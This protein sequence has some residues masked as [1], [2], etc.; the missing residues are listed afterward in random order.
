MSPLATGY[1]NSTYVDCRSHAYGPFARALAELH[2]VVDAIDCNIPEHDSCEGQ[3]Q[4]PGHSSQTSS[5]RNNRSAANTRPARKSLR[6]SDPAHGPRDK[7]DGKAQ[8]PKPGDYERKKATDL[9]PRLLDCPVYKHWFMWL[10]SISPP[11]CNGCSQKHMTQIRNH[12]K[13]AHAGRSGSFIPYYDR[14]IRC[15][16]NFVDHTSFVDHERSHACDHVPEPRGEPII[17]W[18][19]LYLKIYPDATAIPLPCKSSSEI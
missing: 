16:E 10:Q 1:K 3:Q 14:C 9:Q 5:S 8:R 6:T 15:Q 13:R 19:R 11:P 2:Q 17:P 12:I 7:P 4:C 18:A